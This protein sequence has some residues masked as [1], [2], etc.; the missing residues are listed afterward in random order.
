MR[1]RSIM[2]NHSATH[3]LHAALRKTLGTHVHQAGSLVAPDYL[4]FDFAHFSKVSD[5]E[6]SVIEDAV[7][8][9]IQEDIKLHHYRDIH[10]DDAKKMGA[11]MFFGDKIRRSCECCRI[12]RLFQGILRRHACAFHGGYRVLQVSVRRECRERCPAR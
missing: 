12:W 8:Q 7:N 4:R 10:F 6:L 9:R 3:L 5:E 2:R 1:R 11:L